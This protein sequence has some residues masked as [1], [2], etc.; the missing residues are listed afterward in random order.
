M[1]E[2][3]EERWA[4][5]SERGGEASGLAYA[6]AAAMMRQLA[7]EKVHGLCV[8]TTDAARHLPRVKS[9]VST[10]SQPTQARLNKT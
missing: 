4:V 1:G 6:E 3:G 10:T 7:S 2:L 5:I 9:P 8:V